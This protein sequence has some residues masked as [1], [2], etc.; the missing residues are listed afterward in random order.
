MKKT[1]NSILLLMLVFGVA[2]GQFT[3]IGTIQPKSRM[4]VNGTAWFQGDNTPLAANAGAGIGIGFGP[5]GS[6][7]YIFAWDYTSFTSRNL[8]LNHTGGSVMVGSVGTP[9]AKFEVQGNGM[10]AI[11]ANTNTSEG[12]NANSSGG[13]GVIATSTAFIGLYAVSTA[14]ANAGVLAE[15]R[16]IGVQGTATGS[17]VNRQAVRGQLD[18]N[19]PGGTA[20]TFVGNTA[21]FGT[22]S[23]TA[24]AF[25]IDHPTEP[26]TKFLYHSFVESPDMKNLYDGVTTTDANGF[27]TVKMPGWFEALNMD[28]RYQLTVIGQFAQAIVLEELFGNQFV[29]KTDKANVKVSWQVTGTRHDPY[30]NENRIPLEKAKA[31]NEIGKYIYPK[32]YGRS[33][34]DLLDILKPTNLSSTATPSSEK[35]PGNK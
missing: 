12:L 16:Y 26:A 6:G 18:G 23:K 30:A 31:P 21:V 19:V 10:R 34:N 4:H 8:W 33:T 15:G 2:Q 22:L 11:Y 3:G 35:L 25:L 27:S 32:G 7:G 20:G 14:P 29:I 1:T 13:H 24:G 28:F 5:G 9:L 17:D